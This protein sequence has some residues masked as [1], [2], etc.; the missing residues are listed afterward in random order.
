[1]DMRDS[2][3]LQAKIAV[4]LLSGRKDE[5]E[6]WPSLKNPEIAGSREGSDPGLPNT[7]A[8]RFQRL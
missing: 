1:M 5:L 8:Q 3:I 6:A 4:R 7:E 2:E